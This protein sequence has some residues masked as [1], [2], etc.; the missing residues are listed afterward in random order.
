[1]L[2]VLFEIAN[3]NYLYTYIYETYSI[4]KYF[5]AVYLTTRQLCGDIEMT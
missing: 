5:Y 2:D 4:Y 1:M 3:D